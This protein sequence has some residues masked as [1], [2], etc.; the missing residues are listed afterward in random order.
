MN[1]RSCR[2]VVLVFSIIT[3][4]NLSS[5]MADSATVYS[6]WKSVGEWREVAEGRSYW[7]GIYWGV[8]HNV[9]GKGMGHEMA[10]NCPA[11]AEIVDGM[12]TSHG[13]C[14]MVDL[15]GDKIFAQFRGKAVLGEPFKGHQDFTGGSGKYEGIEGGHDFDCRAIGTEQLAC[16]QDMEY[17]LP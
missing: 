7:L 3:V 11:A 12:L 14:T 6:G 1:K 2:L 17:T 5:A 16:R 15:D 8:S 10:W 13:F 9:S 4:F